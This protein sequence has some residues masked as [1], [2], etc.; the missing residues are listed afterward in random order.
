VA[1]GL[2]EGTSLGNLRNVS[3]ISAGL[4]SH[5]STGKSIP[6]RV[7]GVLQMSQRPSR[8][9]SLAL[10]FALALCASCRAPE[11]LAPARWRLGPQVGVLDL[12]SVYFIDESNG[13]AVGGIDIKGA[14]GVIHRTTD[15]GLSWRPI[16]RTP[17][18]LTSVVFINSNTGW[19]AGYAGRI[20]RTDD[21]GHMWRPQRAELGAEIL[22]SLCFIN[23][24]TGWAAGGAGLLLRTLNGGNSW[25]QIQTGRVEDF[26]TV[27]FSSPDKGII[28]GEDGLIFSTSDGGR[29]WAPS[30]FRATAAL[31]GLAIS[32]NG[33]A[34]AV[35]LNG[36]VLV[37]DGGNQWTKVDSITNET[38]DAVASGGD[39]VFWAVGSNGTTI[40]TAD[41]GL[42][43]KHVEPVCSGDLF[44]LAMSG[45]SRGI[46]VGQRGCTQLLRN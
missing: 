5:R 11:S 7:I 39:N 14:G 32:P 22:N 33:R 45:P 17:E 24:S 3:S 4:I 40:E 44:S 29:N 25:E 19:V 1:K 42:T 8:L 10:P 43:W 26:W 23:D 13:W 34:V 18:I 35:G 16:A 12:L 6:Q 41:G 15:G 36:A 28:V 30:P 20:D 21:G 27:K 31:M 9:A 38:L 46:A 2:I 37:T